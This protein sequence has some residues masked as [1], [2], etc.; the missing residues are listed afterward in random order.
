MKC[1]N[2][3]LIIALLSFFHLERQAQVKVGIRYDLGLNF[4]QNVV[5]QDDPSGYGHSG[6]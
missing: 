2:H 6:G 5:H 3:L 4:L 1:I